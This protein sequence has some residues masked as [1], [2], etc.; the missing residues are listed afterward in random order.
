[1]AVLHLETIIKA[2]IE[3][4]F[5]LSRSIDLHRLSMIR[6]NETAVA[7]RTHGLIELGETVTWRARHFGIYQTLT[8]KITALEKYNHFTDTMQKGVFSYMEHTHSFVQSDGITTMNDRFE[9]KA[10]CGLLGRLAETLFLK[11]YMRNLLSER[12]RTIKQIAESED[13]KRLL[14]APID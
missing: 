14:I 7:G 12:N 5:D 6:S 9:F 8:V 13:W 3:R 2:P 10:P 1:M 4:V 11:K